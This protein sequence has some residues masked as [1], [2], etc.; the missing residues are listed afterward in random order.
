MII[1]HYS[2]ICVVQ[3][4]Q[5]VL[6]YRSSRYTKLPTLLTVPGQIERLTC[7]MYKECTVNLGTVQSIV[8]H[9][10]SHL[11]TFAET[12]VNGDV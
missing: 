2:L 5:S 12:S 10:V 6:L 1:T 9:Q 3:E 11:A 8:K 4:V 7:P